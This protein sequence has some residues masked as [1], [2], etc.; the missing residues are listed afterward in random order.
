M[1]ISPDFSGCH[2]H[3]KIT[4]PNF[5]HKKQREIPESHH[6]YH[7]FV[8]FDSLQMVNIITQPKVLPTLWHSNTWNHLNLRQ[9]SIEKF[10]AKR[11][12]G[13]KILL[14]RNGLTEPVCYGW[15]MVLDVLLVLLL[16]LLLL[17]VLLLLLLLLLFHLHIV[18]LITHVYCTLQVC[19]NPFWT[20]V[21]HLMSIIASWH[22]Y[23]TVAHHRPYKSQ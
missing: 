4:N 23:K 3:R 11:S 8:L 21:F 22:R 17:D 18:S 20:L 19:P 14:L 10:V 16:L 7:R 15:C 2:D 5:M 6:R 13:Q 1:V 9:K 12:K